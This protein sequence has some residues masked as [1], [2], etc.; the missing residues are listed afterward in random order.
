[1]SGVKRENHTDA[2]PFASAEQKKNGSVSAVDIV[3]LKS[4]Y[5]LYE[6]YSIFTVALSAIDTTEKATEQQNSLCERFIRSWLDDVDN[7]DNVLR[8]ILFCKVA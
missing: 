4:A 6:I 5:F 3:L 7:R 8:D 2:C 1:M